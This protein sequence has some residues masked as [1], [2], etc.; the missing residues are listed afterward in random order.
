M[1]LIGI[2][3]S[4]SGLV[5]VL[6]VNDSVIARKSDEDIRITLNGHVRAVSKPDVELIGTLTA[7]QTLTGQ[8]TEQQTLTGSLSA[9]GSLLGELTIPEVINEGDIPS[10]YGLIS[11]NGSHLMVS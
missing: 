7:Q 4:S 1:E 6:S 2:L 10:N 8:L 5:G 9:T 11:W 3:S